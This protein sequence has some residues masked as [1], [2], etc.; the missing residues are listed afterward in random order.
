MAQNDT[1]ARMFRDEVRIAA[2][3][4]HPNIV[5]ALDVV[6]SGDEILLAMDYVHGESL[7]QLWKTA[8]E[9]QVPIPPA[10]AS[11]I[12]CGVLN[13]LHTAHEAKDESGSELALVHRDVSP[14]NILVGA[15]GVP[16]L[17]DFGVAKADGRE[18][19][20]ESGS[21]KG[22]LGYL[23]P[24][25][26][27]GTPA[28][29]HADIFGAGVVLWELLSLRR[30]YASDNEGRTL[31]LILFSSPPPLR[32]LRPEVSPELAALVS[33]A[34]ARNP[35]E[36]CKSARAM[37]LELSKI[38]PPAATLEVGE[39]VVALAAPALERRTA[40][41]RELDTGTVEVVDALGMPS[42]PSLPVGTE[43][44]TIATSQATPRREPAR[45]RTVLVIVAL[46]LVAG[47]VVFVARSQELAVTP[48]PSVAARP[49]QSSVNA[50]PAL[51]PSP[52][53]APAAASSTP[54]ARIDATR[55]LTTK[56]LR[57]AANCNP[58]YEL[59]P[60]GGRKWKR[61]CLR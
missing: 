15:D 32:E 37:S 12:I 55:P 4:R 24:E 6:V 1:Y 47:I 46:L 57:P 38:C 17:L 31:D 40:M 27:R 39:W 16:R 51:A 33:K 7:S 54:S 10:I 9:R 41:L 35:A 18:Q 26:I 20:S 19:V 58:P 34:L 43:V 44:T 8:A 45:G 11:A 14:Q 36:R 48:P 22:K 21:I 30:L 28:T 60:S 13:G 56:P 3:I 25:V 50:L 53:V 5:P 29:F 52:S 59:L 61:E 42:S 49:E 2:R 23:A